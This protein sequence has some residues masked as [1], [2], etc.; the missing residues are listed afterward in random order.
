MSTAVA[1]TKPQKAAAILVAMGKP[2]A[3][4]L[5]RFFKQDELKTL[6]EGAR[7]LRTIPQS[8]LERIVAEFE[9][10][11]TEGAGLLDS[12]DEM[13]T[14]LT[15]SFTPEEFSAIMGTEKV[16]TEKGA[17][18]VWPAIERLDAD[19]VGAFLAGEH[20]QTAAL[21]L[22][23]L[24]AQSTAN[25]ILA[26][27]KTFRADV[28]RRLMSTGAVKPQA[29]RIVEERL[30]TALLSASASKD[31]AEGQTR[32][33]SVLNE[34]NKDQLEEVMQEL[35]ASG[36]DDID[37][38]RSRLFS[39]EDVVFLS[40]KHRVALFD[41]INT[42]VVT[43]ALRNCSAELGEAILSSVGVRARRMMESE[44]SNG[45]EG[46]AADEIMRARK[47]IASTAIRLASEGIIELPQ[48]Q[49]NA[50]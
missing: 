35:A 12:A 36:Y 26:L 29:L 43:A 19:R 15:E 13:D 27:P 33:A 23:K 49:Q 32:V 14:L 22:S 44:L 17:P 38:L 6:I 28:V 24:S 37:A 7:A 39:F 45:S 34:L 11:F 18:S 50:A 5:L 41:G 47:T 10:E 42:E 1:L 16:E 4:K 40:Q 9:S 21:V 30:R 3:G 2:A 20:P 8:E 31:V 46:V 48:P 25:I